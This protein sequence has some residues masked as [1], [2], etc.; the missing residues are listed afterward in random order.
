MAQATRRVLLENRKLVAKREDLRLPGG[1]GSKTGCYQGEKSD[2]KRVHRGNHHNLTNG[3]NPCVF[4]SDGVFGNHNTLCPEGLRKFGRGWSDQDMSDLYD[5]I[6][7]D[8]AF[9]KEWAEKAG[10][11]FTI[12]AKPVSKTTQLVYNGPQ[13]AVAGE[14]EKVA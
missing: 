14:T 1:T 8:A 7:E 10:I 5:K 3:W 12:P 6:R 4:R 9:R 13:N 2:E 11:G